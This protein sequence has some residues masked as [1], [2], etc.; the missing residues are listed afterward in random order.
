MVLQRTLLPP[1]LPHVDGLAL[2]SYYYPASPRQVGGDF[3]DV[4]ALGG[5]RWAF[6]IGDVQGHGTEAAAVTSLIRYTL[7]SAA[8]HY[9]D[10]TDGLA[11]LNS[12]LLREANPRRFSSYGNEAASP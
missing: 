8:L 4:F 6:F 12:V 9:S 7:R 1:S 3:Y 10:P 2:A 5:N 11:E